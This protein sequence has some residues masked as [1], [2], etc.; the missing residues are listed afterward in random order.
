L[1]TASILS[2]K[3]AAGL[4][5]LVLDVKIGNGAFMTS[6]D[7]A[8]TLARSLVEVANGAG[9]RTSALVTDM[10]QPLANAAGNALETFASGEQRTWA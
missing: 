2:K 5:T 10:N 4:Q 8:G 1:I 6:L 9:L 3:L 7:E